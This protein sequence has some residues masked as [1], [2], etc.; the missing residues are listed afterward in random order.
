MKGLS[1]RNYP[2]TLA[3]MRGDEVAA[4]MFACLSPKLRDAIHGGPIVAG[5][6]YPVAWKRELHAA[7]REATGEPRLAWTMGLEMTKR[8]LTGIYRVFLRV[9][10]PQYVLS[11]GSRIFSTY[12]RRGTMRVVATRRGFVNVSFVDCVGFDRNMWLD[13]LGG[14]QATLEAAGASA[15]RLHIDRGGGDGDSETTATAWWATDGDS[16][17]RDAGS[18]GPP[19][20]V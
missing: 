19:P 16:E 7:G 5:G 18:Q 15:V 2:V 3:S 1:L 4:K 14:C 11:A 20:I 13:V 12:F 9:V 6:W 10:S 17:Q 8:D